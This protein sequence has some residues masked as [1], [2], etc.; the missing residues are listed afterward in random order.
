M[1]SSV[2]VIEMWI[3][4]QIFHQKS[5][6]WKKIQL[7]F[8]IR[9]ECLPT[10]S[11]IF[12]AHHHR[13]SRTKNRMKIGKKGQIHISLDR[14]KQTAR[15]LWK[16]LIRGEQWLVIYSHFG[17]HRT[18]F[19]TEKIF[20]DDFTF[21][22]MNKMNGNKNFKSHKMDGDVWWRMAYDQWVELREFK[23][24]STL[25]QHQELT[26]SVDVISLSIV[27]VIVGLWKWN[28][29]IGN[30]GLESRQSFIIAKAMKL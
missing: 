30:S 18:S 23:L 10:P 6:Q 27:D 19:S 24:N 15:N 22:F 7:N 8:I 9:F 12:H 25:V 4:L 16:F 13:L 26:L 2:D 3:I 17:E 29:L 21:R 1:S 20:R 5:L 28:N 11:T 14:M